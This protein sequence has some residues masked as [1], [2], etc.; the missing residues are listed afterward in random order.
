MAE[1][2]GRTIAI[3]DVHGCIHALEALIDA[4]APGPSD[5]LVFLG[6]LVDHGRNSREVLNRLI[7]LESQCA[8]TLIQGNHEEMML[9]AR[10]SDAALN[11][12]AN[13]GGVAAL[14]S[15][16][17]GGSLADIPTAHWELVERCIPYH[18]TA[19]HIFTHANYSPHLPMAYQPGHRLRWALFDHQELE[20]HQSGKIVVVGHTEQ[21]NGEIV[22][23]GFVNCIDT[24]CCRYGW[25]TAIEVNSANGFRLGSNMWQASAWGVLREPGEATQRERL[26]DLLQSPK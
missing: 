13:C 14:N 6:D 23:L 2:A 10:E 4:I 11:F 19:D 20:P 24:A 18:E 26:G 22:D 1:H 9:A 12:W 15:Y 8:V 16:R 17:F 5:E 3:G 25:L 7:E 21:R